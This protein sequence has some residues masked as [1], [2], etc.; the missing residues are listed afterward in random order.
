[1]AGLCKGGNEP[2]GFLK[3]IFNQSPVRYLERNTKL[4]SLEYDVVTFIR[5]GNGSTWPL[6]VAS[7]VRMRSNSV[8]NILV[9]S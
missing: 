2:A 9:H 4:F 6:I 8:T 7:V 5:H 3:A 1:M